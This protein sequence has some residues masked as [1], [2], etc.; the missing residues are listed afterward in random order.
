MVRIKYLAQFANSHNITWD[1]V[2]IG[3]WSTLEVHLSIIIACLPALRAFFVHLF[4]RLAPTTQ[5]S[6]NMYSSNASKTT[7]GRSGPGI[8]FSQKVDHFVEL[9][10]LE[11]E[12][13]LVG[14]GKQQTPNGKSPFDSSTARHTA[15]AYS[16][17][18][19]RPP[20][21]RQDN[22]YKDYRQ[23]GYHRDDWS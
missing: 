1:Y 18:A 15:N 3:Y 22:S 7:N 2:P 21:A 10:D 5:V 16:T 17:S 8:H 11:S 4:P 19:A 12:Q 9:T 14:D 13:A 23:Y 6:K 20:A